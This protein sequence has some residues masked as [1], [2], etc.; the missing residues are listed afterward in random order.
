MLRLGGE[1]DDPVHRDVEVVDGLGEAGRDLDRRVE[2]EPVA[3]VAAEPASLQEGR[4]LDGAAAHEDV[5]GPHG[6]RLVD[7]IGSS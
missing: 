6:Q 4:G 2:L 7:A 5:L 3:D 1:L